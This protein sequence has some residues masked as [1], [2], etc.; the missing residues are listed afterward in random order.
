MPAYCPGPRFVAACDGDRSLTPKGSVVTGPYLRGG[1]GL[2]TAFPAAHLLDGWGFAV[3]S[4]FAHGVA[5][6]RGKFVTYPT[7]NFATLGTF[8]TTT[9]LTRTRGEIE[10]RGGHFCRPPH[11]AMGVG[12]YLGRL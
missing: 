5:P 1:R 9:R 8:V 11:I 2:P 10:Q 3:M 7:R 6:V 4:G 12:L